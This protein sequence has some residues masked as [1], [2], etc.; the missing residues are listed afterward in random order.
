MDKDKAMGYDDDVEHTEPAAASPSEVDSDFRETLGSDATAEQLT[1][2]QSLGD[3][4]REG[5]DDLKGEF[6]D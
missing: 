6:S 1:E 4:L 2:D 5:Y 3:K